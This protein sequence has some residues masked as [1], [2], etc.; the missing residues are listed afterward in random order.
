MQEAELQPGH[1]C[2]QQKLQEENLLRL[3]MVLIILKIQLKNFI[4]L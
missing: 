3:F 1:V 4:I 2:L